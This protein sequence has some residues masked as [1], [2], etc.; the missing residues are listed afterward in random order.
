M[1]E[2]ELTYLASRL[3]EGLGSAPSKEIIDIYVPESSPHPTLRLR[4][5]GESYEITKK[6][7]LSAG[8]ASAQAEETIPLSAEEFQALSAAPSRKVRKIRYYLDGAEIDVFQDGL[9]G[10]VVIDFEFASEEEK[11]A[12]EAP[13]Y[14][15]AEITQETFVAGGMLAGKVYADIAGI[16]DSWGYEPIAA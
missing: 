5:N 2:Y 7:P 8:D 14:C 13:A 15:L 9:A 3:P 4:K 11:A 1:I 12:F 6:T 16:L 10:L